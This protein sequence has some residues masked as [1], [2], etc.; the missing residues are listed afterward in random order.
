MNSFTRFLPRSR[1]AASVP[2][3][4]V[5]TIW[6]RSDFS[7]TCSVVCGAAA[8]FAASLAIATLLPFFFLRSK[9]RAQLVELLCARHGVQQDVAQLVVGL[10]LTLQIAQA[11]AEFEQ[12]TQ[13][14]HL[15]SHL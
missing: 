7:P 10:K 14:L 15:L 2:T 6:S 12:L 5:S 8:A 9:L 1:L 3:R 13:R 4:P 11:R